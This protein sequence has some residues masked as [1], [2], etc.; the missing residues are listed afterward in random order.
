MFIEVLGLMAALGHTAVLGYRGGVGTNMS[1]EK[2]TLPQGMVFVFI[3][4]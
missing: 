4:A 3:F 1:T 2:H